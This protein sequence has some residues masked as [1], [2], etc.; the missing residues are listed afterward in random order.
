MEILNELGTRLKM[1]R[2]YSG[3]K[4]K[5]L[6]EELEIPASLLSMYEQGKREPSI[7]FLYSFCTR[8]DMTLSQ[9]FSFHNSIEENKT[10]P[11]FKNFINDLQLLLSDFERNKFK[12][13]NAV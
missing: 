1:I 8:F 6:A 13:L 7:S 9:L 2:V 3:I 10:K 5:R 4:Q 12:G 11:E